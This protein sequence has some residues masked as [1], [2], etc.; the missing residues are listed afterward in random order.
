MCGLRLKSPIMAASGVT[1]RNGDSIAKAAAGGAAAAVT[2]TISSTPAKVPRPCIARVRDGIVSSDMFSDMTVEQWVK[3]EMPKAKRSGIHIIASVG[4]SPEDVKKVAPRMV[5]AGADGI[6][7]PVPSNAKAAL[8]L[9]GAARDS[10]NVPVFA[11]LMEPLANSQELA[12]ELESSGVGGIVVGGPIGPC[13]S[14]DVESSMPMLGAPGGVGYMSG[15]PVK[16]MILKCVAD[17]ARSVSIPVVG[18][19]GV[20]SGRDIVE[21]VMAGA[22][23]VQVSTAAI[24]RGYKVYGF[25]ADELVKFMR[26]KNYDGLEDIRGRALHHLPTEPLRTFSSPVEIIASKCTACGI[27]ESSCPYGAIRVTGRVAKV[28]SVKCYGCGLCVSM[29]PTH[30]IRF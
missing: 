13:L 24:L 16:P 11:K 29:C 5:E 25:L 27:C 4:P 3:F 9:V 28:D 6:E 26:V 30:A 17:V 21:Y 10:V 15:P 2:K 7:I 14:I 18:C 20:S 22:W 8:E 23:A 19:G 12:R 1:T